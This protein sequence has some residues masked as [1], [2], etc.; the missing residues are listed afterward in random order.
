MQY[1]AY[2]LHEYTY[3]IG[4]AESALARPGRWTGG[5]DRGDGCTGCKRPGRGLYA[6]AKKKPPDNT[7]GLELFAGW[8]GRA[9]QLCPD[10][11]LY[12]LFDELR[13]LYALDGCGLFDLIG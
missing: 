6:W 9:V 7:E 12:C 11:V 2:I 10:R 5:I 3:A 1:I 8:I 13:G 4:R